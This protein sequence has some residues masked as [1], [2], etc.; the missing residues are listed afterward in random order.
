MAP[1]KWN[2]EGRIWD[3][4]H[5]LLDD[6]QV[7]Q[8]ERADVSEPLRAPIPT[9][10]V[11]NGEYM[12][13]PQT[14]PQKQVEA[15]LFELADSASRKLGVSRRYFLKS[16]GGMAAALLAMNEVFGEM[17]HIRPSSFHFLGAIPAYN[18]TRLT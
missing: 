15:R 14:G 12:P 16:S 10:M 17:F 9:R 6:E 1:E 3:D 18:P 5:V 7:T 11:S 8:C 4:D 2:E 13:I